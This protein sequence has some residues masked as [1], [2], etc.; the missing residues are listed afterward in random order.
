MVKKENIDECT[1]DTKKKM[2]FVTTS[3]R[4]DA[5]R[6]DEISEIEWMLYVNRKTESSSKQFQVKNNNAMFGSFSKKVNIRRR[7]PFIVMNVLRRNVSLIWEK[8]EEEKEEKNSSS[9]NQ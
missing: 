4:R 9:E 1:E 5:E 6:N 2:K 3:A 8:K 7:A